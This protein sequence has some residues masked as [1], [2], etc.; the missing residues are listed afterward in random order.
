M[1]PMKINFRLF[2]SADGIGGRI[3]DIIKTNINEQE[4]D[5]QK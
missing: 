2:G 4:Q 3:S 5:L 1:M